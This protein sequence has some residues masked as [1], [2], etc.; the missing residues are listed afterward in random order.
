MNPAPG[1]E[2]LVPQKGQVFVPFHTAVL[3]DVFDD[4][5]Q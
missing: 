2:S 5:I 1:S 3:F 4:S